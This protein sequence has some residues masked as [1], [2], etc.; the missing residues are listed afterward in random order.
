[1]LRGNAEM[2]AEVALRVSQHGWLGTER[3]AGIT[4]CEMEYNWLD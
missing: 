3:S 2:D 1:M 4:R